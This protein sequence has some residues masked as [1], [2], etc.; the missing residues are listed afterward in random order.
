[1]KKLSVWLIVLGLILVAVPPAGGAFLYYEQ[2]N[3][4]SRYQDGLRAGQDADG[5]SIMNENF[6]DQVQLPSGDQ[7]VTGP[8]AD[9]E[10]SPRKSVTDSENVLGDIDIPSIDSSLLLLEG[11]SSRELRFGAGHVT[12]T[13]MPGQ[14]GNCAVAGHRN[15]TFGTYF[16]RLD[17]VNP[18]DKI[19]VNYDGQTFTYLAEESFTVLP[20]DTWV[21]EPPEDDDETQITLIT[22]TPRGGSTHRLVVRG[23]LETNKDTNTEESL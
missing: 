6:L 4:R 3:L 22:C 19:S 20:A 7:S 8:A 18:G 14:R 16:S 17:E 15:Y 10:G 1:M 5:P 23:R 2:Q 21:L 13:A 11:S 12:G 9:S